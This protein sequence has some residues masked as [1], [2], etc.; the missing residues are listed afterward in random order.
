M[1]AFYESMTLPGL[2]GSVAVFGM[3]A[4]ALLLLFAKPMRRLEEGH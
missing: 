3:V 1:A 4:G 2:F